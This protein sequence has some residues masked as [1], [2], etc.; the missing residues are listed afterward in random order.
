MGNVQTAQPT[1]TEPA[2]DRCQNCNCETEEHSY[3]T[4]LYGTVKNYYRHIILC[5]GEL[6]WV[7]KIEKD[8]TN[9]ASTISKM[10]KQY[11]GG[12]FLFFLQISFSH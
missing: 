8:D 2:S 9:I 11:E 7:R 6:D 12:L 10:L 5:S 1:K 4:K 3:N